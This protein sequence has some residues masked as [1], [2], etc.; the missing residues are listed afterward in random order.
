MDIGEVAPGGTRTLIKGVT[1]VGTYNLIKGVTKVGT[2]NLIKGAT[3]V[4]THKDYVTYVRVQDIS[5][6][7]APQ[8]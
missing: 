2:Y 3:K 5:A 1:K 6:A 7:N 4:G 8:D